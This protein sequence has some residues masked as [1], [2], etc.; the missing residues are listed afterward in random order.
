M[1]QKLPFCLGEVHG[2]ILKRYWHLKQAIAVVSG[3]FTLMSPRMSWQQQKT[4]VVVGL[5]ELSK[6]CYNG[7]EKCNK[8]RLMRGMPGSGAAHSQGAPLTL[9]LA[10][11]SMAA[12]VG[13]RGC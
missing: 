8:R 9:G 7:T 6:S 13:A 12:I 4:C 2:D 10:V 5:R 3:E 1:I 11:R